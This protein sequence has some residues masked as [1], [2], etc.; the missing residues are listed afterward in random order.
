[1]KIRI[2]KI[3]FP[4]PLLDDLIDGK[5]VVFA[6]AG[7][8][9]G[10]PANLPSF[11]GLVEELSEFAEEPLG[12][13]ES[14][15]RFLG[16]LERQGVHVHHLTRDFL[17]ERKPQPTRLHRNI[18]RLYPN[19]KEVKIVTTNFDSLFERAARHNNVF[20]HPLKS[21]Y[22]PALPQGNNF[23]GI[24]HIHGTIDEPEKMILTNID[25]GNAYLTQGWARHFVMD[26]F[27][28][29]SV[30][31]IGYS[32][33]DVMMNYILQSLLRGNR[34]R[35][36]ALTEETN[37]SEWEK[38]GI[39]PIPY[40]PKNDHAALYEGIRKVRNFVN[41]TPQD[42]EKEIQKIAKDHPPKDPEKIGVL[43]MI[44]RDEGR[45]R[46]FT[47]HAKVDPWTKWLF[48]HRYLDALFTNRDLGI[49]ESM[50]AHFVANIS[51]TEET[52]LLNLIKNNEITIHPSFWFNLTSKIRESN[53][54]RTK[55]KILI[56]TQWVYLLIS[57]SPKSSLLMPYRFSWHNIIDCCGKNNMLECLTNILIFFLEK[58]IYINGGFS[59]QLLQKIVYIWNDKL[60]SNIHSIGESLLKK[61]VIQ[62]EKEH[63]MSHAGKNPNEI[64][65]PS[66]IRMGE[67]GDDYT[68]KG[69]GIKSN[70]LFSILVLIMR[71]CLTY[72]AKE[73]KENTDRW[74][75]QLI[76]SD[77][78]ILRRMSAYILPFRR[79]LSTR[80]KIEWMVKYVDLSDQSVRYEILK[81]LPTIYMSANKSSRAKILSFLFS[82][83]FSSSNSEIDK[84]KITMELHFS[85]AKSIQK[86]IPHC[87]LLSKKIKM[88]K[89]TNPNLSSS[90]TQNIQT[91]ETIGN[92]I[93][94]FSEHFLSKPIQDS[95]KKLI[96]L[97]PQKP[98][99]R[100]WDLM[101]AIGDAVKENPRWG[102]GFAEELID[103]EEWKSDIWGFLIHELSS[104]NLDK[105]LH[106]RLLNILDNA[107][108]QNEQTDFFC[109]SLFSLSS[110]YKKNN[111]ATFFS[112]ANKIAVS[113]WEKTKKIPC[114]SSELDGD[115]FST[116]INHPAG[117]LGMFW[118]HSIE[119]WRNTRENI[120]NHLDPTHKKA[121]SVIVQE[122][123][124]SGK[125][126]QCIL[127]S[128][129]D[130]LLS[131][132]E[133]WTKA[134]LLPLFYPEKTKDTMNFVFVWHGFLASQGSAHGLV[135]KVLKSAFLQTIPY[136]KNIIPEVRKEFLSLCIVMFTHAE[137][138]PF[139]GW[140]SNI[141]KCGQET[142]DI[143]ASQISLYL[144][145]LDKDQQK[146]CWDHW[147][148]KYWEK[149]L[150]GIYAP[151]E[152]QE[153]IAQMLEWV[154]HLTE[155][156]PEAVEMAL[157]MPLISQMQH[158]I[159][160]K[161]LR[162]KQLC[163]DYPNEMV[164]FLSHVGKNDLAPHMWSNETKE[165]I[166]EL[167][168]K[169]LKKT[170]KKDL[171]D[172]ILKIRD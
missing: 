124:I 35:V 49:S 89:Q 95:V 52:Y 160:M 152:N 90:K 107:H 2:G 142:R 20:G 138:N 164:Q 119:T 36:F 132:D 134:C 122:P 13:T 101:A 102:L 133:K 120:S 150:Y 88:I 7:V 34:S 97:H 154:P 168:F 40:S 73:K 28:N 146:K 60:K 114:S 125:L 81:A 103:R 8:S 77:P 1:M 143:F 105:D 17:S 98:E 18:L 37:S 141:C 63:H 169:R 109:W 56:L 47:K 64:F 45:I 30:L 167:R 31:L 92:Q 171:N 155:K 91:T 42:W 83:E 80:K 170:I 157:K 165:I 11:R 87:S 65:D 23:N 3:D 166:T 48:K 129:F 12:K 82:F 62:I 4:K 79:D 117:Q 58:S 163:E 16:R 130:F 140:I 115:L 99:K 110:I 135:S 144:G 15:D 69:R 131:I 21:Y 128:E 161:L 93:P 5:V 50:L 127:A 43:E 51:F 85:W 44:L 53:A 116:S 121:L 27:L 24:V 172:L 70:D 139:K 57:S 96:S 10:K 147:L 106:K 100:H 145:K 123:S 86:N 104:K 159:I 22:A 78:P 39:E 112:L 151:L 108:L 75:S 6:G 156:F 41:F 59:D 74:C 26:L 149:R 9:M 94:Y 153:E 61:I 137:E 126:G 71:D 19:H 148:K 29:Q 84:K 72:I 67:I 118:I 68:R 38:S 54:N 113:L 14:E 33:K 46:F 55:N 111:T 66:I 158:S 25:F 136:M 162:K 76:E 32:N